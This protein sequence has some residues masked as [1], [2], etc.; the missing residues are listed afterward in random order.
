ML[1]L[2]KFSEV[3]MVLLHQITSQQAYLN[4]LNGLWFY[5]T[6]PGSARSMNGVGHCTAIPFLEHSCE[7]HNKNP[8]SDTSEEIN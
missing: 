8:W 3:F 2:R 1:A 4:E 6:L 7:A 5:I